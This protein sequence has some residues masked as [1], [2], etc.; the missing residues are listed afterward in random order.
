MVRLN[1]FWGW[2][3]SSRL[4]SKNLNENGRARQHELDKLAL[5]AA[6]VDALESALRYLRKSTRS[7]LTSVKSDRNWTSTPP[8]LFFNKKFMDS[9]CFFQLMPEGGKSLL[10]TAWTTPFL[11]PKAQAILVLP[12]L[13]HLLTPPLPFPRSERERPRK[14]Q[15]NHTLFLRPPHR[16]QSM[17]ISVSPPDLCDA[18]I[19][20]WQ[21]VRKR[22]KSR[23]QRRK[24]ER[25][26]VRFESPKAQ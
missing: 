21:L 20:P 10:M 14:Q 15:R 7:L 12:S 2:F 8:L 1:V 11:S 19:T 18:S 24:E 23:T 4:E 22:R 9:R 25:W 26:K 16:P 5:T 3:R 13:L 6:R 17:E